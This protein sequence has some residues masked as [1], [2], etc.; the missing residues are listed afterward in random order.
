ME[1]L[2]L[3]D[4]NIDKTP[5]LEG[6]LFS[7]SLGFSIP[8]HDFINSLVAQEGC[9]NYLFHHTHRNEKNHHNSIQLLFRPPRIQSDS[10]QYGNTAITGNTKYFYHTDHL[11]SVVNVTDEA[12]VSVWENDYT[13]FEH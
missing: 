6:F 7:G 10:T 4:K 2:V 5:S 11:G 8:I 12:G 3:I 9:N 13:P 1:E